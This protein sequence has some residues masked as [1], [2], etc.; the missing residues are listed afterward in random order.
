[1]AATDTSIHRILI[2]D[3]QPD[4]LEALRLLLKAE[5]Y[6]IET[7]KSPAAVIKAIEARDFSLVLMDL[8]Y[9]RDTTSGQEGLDL[10]NKIQTIDS[11]LPV[12]VMTAWASVDVAVEAMRRG[13][14]DFI[15]KPWDNP[16]LIAIVRN[17]IDLG[18]AVRAYRRLRTG[19]PAAAR[20]G[21]AQ[22][23]RPI[24]RHA[25]RARYHRAGR[26]VRRQRPASPAR[27]ARARD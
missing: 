10:L 23:D 1:M 27:T 22:P 20:Q 9:E 26:P 13:A 14:R 21:R 3:D 24:R 19:K 4:V 12:V 6:Q 5:G 17:Q 7:V 2:A 18:N 15:T 11:S 8:N 25:A 16:R